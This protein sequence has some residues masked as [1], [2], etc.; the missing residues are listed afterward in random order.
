VNL[1]NELRDAL[2]REP[3]PEGFAARVLV[4]SRAAPW[5]RRPA[6]LALAA[7][8]AVAALIP[9]A[10]EYRLRQQRRALEARDQLMAALAVTRV[11]LQH[12]RE[13]IQRN[14]RHTL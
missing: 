1:E 2:R 9:S 11:Q 6:A 13:R 8:L 10:I 7:G 12:V 4:K 3:A 14:T 5:W